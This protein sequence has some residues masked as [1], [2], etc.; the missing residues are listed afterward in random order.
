MPFC[1]FLLANVINLNQMR[2]CTAVH[3]PQ[4]VNE[5]ERSF[6][7]KIIR[8]K[9]YADMS[10]KAA[11]IISAQVIMKPNCVLG[12]AT[13]GTPVGIYEKLVE[14]Y[15][16]G[17]LDFSEVTSVN[18]DEYRGLPK[19]HPE[20]YWSFM[21]RNLFD[22]VNIDPAKINL[23]DGTN[24]DAEDACA[25]YNQIIHAVGGIDLQLLGIGH[26]GHIGFNEPGEAFELET[27]CVDLT[28]ETIEANKRF[29]DGNVDL[30]PKQAYTMGIK[31][32]M[33]AR[34]V[35]MVANGKGKAEIVKKAFFGPVTPEVPASILQ[36]HPDFTLVGDEEA[37]SLI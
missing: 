2:A 29:F 18:L 11:N 35:L 17:D 3:R 28:P 10:R 30:V 7:V 13:G 4:G 8:T 27:H 24:P 1:G 16:E 9:D 19:E 31:T 22:K 36:M 6:I 25:K 14:R 32:I 5:E 20:S 34:K 21:H 33:Q 12:L 37:L 23:P 15:N 26:D